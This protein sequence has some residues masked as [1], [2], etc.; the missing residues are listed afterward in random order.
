MAGYLSPGAYFY[1][2]EQEY[3]Q[4]YEDVLERYKGRA[5]L[6]AAGPPLPPRLPLAPPGVAGAA[7]WAR[8]RRRPEGGPAAPSPGVVSVGGERAS[9]APAGNKNAAC[10][11]PAGETR[12]LVL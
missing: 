5:A 10:P 11:S 2:E 1:A 4:A 6:P 3:L 7:R 8:P 9:V 12:S